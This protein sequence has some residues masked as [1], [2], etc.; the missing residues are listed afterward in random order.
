[1]QPD[2]EQGQ[3][4]AEQAA[5]VMGRPTDYDP[6]YA[7]QAKKL[8]ELGATDA[9][10]ADFFGVSTKTIDRWKVRYEDF[11]LSLKNGKDIPD[12]Q[13]ERSLYQKARGYVYTEQVAIKV[14]SVEY[15]DGKK[16][17]ETEDIKVIDVERH[18]PPDTTAQI[19]WLK[20]R[21]KA[22][23]RDRVET[24]VTVGFTEEFESFIRD[25]RGD[26]KVLAAPIIDGTVDVDG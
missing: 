18:A 3:S 22:E 10:L 23:W 25:L 5:A 7:R 19:F 8:C 1:M 2:P 20:N 13:V 14:K 24:A 11:C 4:M 6:D 17:A 26:K 15:A 21:R 9:Q 16:V 12:D